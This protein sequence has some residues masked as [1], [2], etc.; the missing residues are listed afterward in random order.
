[1]ASPPADRLQILVAGT[2]EER[3]AALAIRW[4]V[5]VD[6]QGVP[7]ELERDDRDPAAT[8]FLARLDGVPIGAARLVVT[9]GAVGLV[10]RVAVLRPLRSAGIGAA[11]MAGVEDRARTLGLTRLELH[12]QTYVR[13]FYARLGYA[14]DGTE[15]L[16]AGIPHVTMRKRLTPA[17]DTPRGWRDTV[18][19]SC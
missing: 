18:G 7:P 1:V 16:E 8:H 3:A 10:G 6:E 2:V 12:A 13:G 19:G 9:D 11:I 5:F 17:G 15:Y 14:E 4:T